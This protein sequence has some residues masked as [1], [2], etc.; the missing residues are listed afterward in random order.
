MSTL[1]GA[2]CESTGDATGDD[3]PL[4][5][6][7]STPTRIAL[8]PTAHPRKW[9]A[10]SWRTNNATKRGYVQIR[11]AGMKRVI[12]AGRSR[13]VT[14]PEWDYTSRHHAAVVRKLRPDTR[15]RYRVGVRGAWSRW[16]RFRTAHGPHRRWQ[17]AYF[18]DAQKGLTTTWP[19]TVDRALNGRDV[20]LI[21]HAGDLVNDPTRDRQWSAWFRALR[22]Y[23]RTTS[24]MPAV[25]NHELHGDKQLRMYRA[26]FRLPK[27]GPRPTTYAIDY[28]GV[29]FVVLDANH[30]ED[31]AQ[32]R[33][34]RSK[35]HHARHRWTVVLFHKPMFASTHDRDTRAQRSAWLR[36]LERQGADLV[37]QGHDHVYARGYL[38]RRADAAAKPRKS[39][40]YAVSDSGGKYYSMDNGHDWTS[41]GARR[42]KA[43]EKVT[44]YQVIRVTPRALTY[45]SIVSAKGKGADEHVGEVIDRFRV[46]R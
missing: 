26:Q 23:R 7:R 4:R 31:R 40:M 6:P 21:L 8:T 25:G 37:L 42:V 27:N 19:H 9:Q 15:Y 36:I 5:E 29:R 30:P 18:G 32:R 28:Q 41:H 24:M 3:A 13:R 38:R 33:F 14:F 43:A 2:G 17:F 45:R 46:K 34:L 1:V 35:L 39:P 44:T 12:K 16:H 10:F 20:D 22:P 11:H